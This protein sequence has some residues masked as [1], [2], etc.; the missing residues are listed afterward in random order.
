MFIIKFT[1][2]LNIRYNYMD[3]NFNLQERLETLETLESKK[4][5]N[6][7]KQPDLTINLHR[8]YFL[9][10]FI[11]ESILQN[12]VR[13]K[14]AIEDE[15]LVESQCVPISMYLLARSLEANSS[16]Y[17]NHSLEDLTG[18]GK[19]SFSKIA[20]KV[21]QDIF[22]SVDVEGKRCDTLFNYK[23]IYSAQYGAFTPDLSLGIVY[24]III[25]FLKRYP[26]ESLIG[27]TNKNYIIIP[28]GY[29]II[30]IKT[31]V[32]DG[33]QLLM[34]IDIQKL[35]GIKHD[36]SELMENI[37]RL[38]QF[39]D[40]LYEGI[41][42]YDFW[43]AKLQQYFVNCVDKWINPPKPSTVAKKLPSWGPNQKTVSVK[44]I[45]V[46]EE[47]KRIAN[48][49]TYH[50]LMDSLITQNTTFALGS[51]N[52]VGA[53]KKKK[54][55]KKRKKP[56]KKKKSK[57]NKSKEKKSKEKKSKEKKSKKREK[58]KLLYFI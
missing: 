56:S 34:V 57:R 49:D 29:N 38:V 2:I 26:K 17:K 20:S 3:R 14:S 51:I 1:I 11:S 7:E 55:S 8:D 54:K 42:T 30:G 9:G 18:V 37:P 4:V 45:A 13:H 47:K 33:H 10:V 52:I 27:T 32:K 43:Y 50:L 46:W 44:D 36:V 31:K 21:I 12:I 19:Q 24:N 41:V 5:K 22:P 6:D 23:N 35:Y 53:F 48:E 28:F 15:Y 25:P 40:N 58:S 39:I 16:F